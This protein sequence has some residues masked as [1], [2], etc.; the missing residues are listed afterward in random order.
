MHRFE[1]ERFQD[2]EVERPLED[3]CGSIAGHEP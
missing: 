2:E 3:V 1:G